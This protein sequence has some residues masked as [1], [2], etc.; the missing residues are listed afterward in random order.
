MLGFLTP[1]CSFL[2]VLVQD[3]YVCLKVWEMEIKQ[4]VAEMDIYPIYFGLSLIRIMK[5]YVSLLD[6]KLSYLLLYR[7]KQSIK[8]K[9]RSHYK[10]LNFVWSLVF[11]R[12][13]GLTT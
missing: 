11:G 6:A 7:C 10:Y 3:K 13:K 12:P 4:I 9:I 2:L 1:N 8:K 5:R